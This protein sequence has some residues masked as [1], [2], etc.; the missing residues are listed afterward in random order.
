[1]SL[2]PVLQQAA[3]IPSSCCI[4]VVVVV[5]VV[6]VKSISLTLGGLLNQDQEIAFE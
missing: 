4:V 3:P 5:E 6:V 1:M 2:P